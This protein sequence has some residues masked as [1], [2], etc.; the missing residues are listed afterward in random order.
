MN[1]ETLSESNKPCLQTSELSVYSKI[2][3][4]PTNPNVFILTGQVAI[5]LG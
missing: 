4:L 1:K 3:S 2:L 5:L